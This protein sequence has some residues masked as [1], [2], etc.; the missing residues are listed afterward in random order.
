MHANKHG[1]ARRNSGP[2]TELIGEPMRRVQVCL[3]ARTIDLLRVLG[4]S[5]VSKGIRLSARE[6]YDRYQR[7]P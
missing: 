2:K 6:A 3:D 7:S 1:G 5:N 4:G